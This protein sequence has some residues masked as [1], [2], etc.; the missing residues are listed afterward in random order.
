MYL[1]FTTHLF[2]ACVDYQSELSVAD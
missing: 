1:D 2:Y